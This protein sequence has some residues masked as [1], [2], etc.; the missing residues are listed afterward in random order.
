[1]EEKKEEE[2]KEDQESNNK[3]TTKTK[4][5]FTKENTE[6]IITQKDVKTFMNN[7]NTFIGN[8]TS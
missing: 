2:K 4:E 5:G 7:I 6:G 8:N 1:M 3:K